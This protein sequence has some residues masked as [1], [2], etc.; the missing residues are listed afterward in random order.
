MF[1]TRRNSK[2]IW[3]HKAVYRT[4]MAIADDGEL[5]VL[6]PGVNKFG[7]DDENDVLIRN[8][9]CRKREGLQL[10]KENEDLQNTHLLQLTLSMV[11]PMVDFQLPMQLRT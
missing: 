2:A 1:L 9:I 4:R 5:I 8:M 6:A 3:L 10:T 7:E 11:L